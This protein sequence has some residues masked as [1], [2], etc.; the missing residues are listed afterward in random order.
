MVSH[1]ED[2]EIEL[3]QS[4]GIRDHVDWRYLPMRGRRRSKR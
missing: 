1:M 3:P 2:R 4:R